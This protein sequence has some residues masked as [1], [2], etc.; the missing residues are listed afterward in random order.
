MVLKSDVFAYQNARKL[1]LAFCR[2]RLFSKI[3]KIAFHG[4]RDVLYIISGD[5]KMMKKVDSIQDVVNGSFGFWNKS[6]VLVCPQ[7]NK[8]DYTELTNY[9]LKLNN[10]PLDGQSVVTLS[11]VEEA[12]S[13]L[14]LSEESLNAARKL[15]DDIQEIRELT[16]NWGLYVQNVEHENASSD[17]HFDVNERTILT[18]YKGAA[19]QTASA[20][21]VIGYEEDMASHTGFVKCS[22]SDDAEL[23]EIENGDVFSITG[24]QRFIGKPTPHR[25]PPKN[26]EPSLVL[27]AEPS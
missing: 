19:T 24:T 22:V 14:S 26:G 12:M 23:L 7:N 25:R 21:D 3:R 6:Q 5:K 17:W 15:Y 2:D 10:V 1:S 27:I 8:F 16:D 13:D 20:A 11:E 4:A 18:K 9:F